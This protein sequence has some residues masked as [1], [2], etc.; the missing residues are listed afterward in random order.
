MSSTYCKLTIPKTPS[1]YMKKIKPGTAWNE[2]PVLRG[3][4]I[5]L[6]ALQ[7]LFVPRDLD[8]GH[9]ADQ[10]CLGL[11]QRMLL[12]IVLCICGRGRSTHPDFFHS[13]AARWGHQEAKLRL[14]QTTRLRTDSAQPS[15]QRNVRWTRRWSSALFGFQVPTKTLLSWLRQLVRRCP[16]LG[17]GHQRILVP[18]DSEKRDC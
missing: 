7:Q 17:D 4:P 8:L 3:G 12:Q 10:L 5:L 11:G 14:E 1:N 13:P 18:A 16:R 15:L 6:G 9:Q 2:D